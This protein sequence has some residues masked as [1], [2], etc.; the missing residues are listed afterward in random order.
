[1]GHKVVD[2]PYSALLREIFTPFELCGNRGDLAEGSRGDLAE[3]SGGHRSCDVVS[4][5]RNPKRE[6]S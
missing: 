6:A 1:M 4:G 3:G 2:C 5:A